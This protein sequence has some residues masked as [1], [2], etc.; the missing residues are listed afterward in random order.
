M[1]LYVAAYDISRDWQR[2]RVA[3]ILREYGRRIQRS[4]FEVEIEPAELDEL[5]FRVGLHLAV[6]DAFDLFPIDRRFPRRRIAWQ[7]D[8]APEDPVIVI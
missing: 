1:S 8:P 7:R 2:T 6:N 3:E 5:L 4:V